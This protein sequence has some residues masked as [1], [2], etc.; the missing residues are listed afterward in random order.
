MVVKDE[1]SNASDLT[2][3]KRRT[4]D[5]LAE[6]RRLSLQPED[7]PGILLTVCERQLMKRK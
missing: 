2:E 7:F 5:D 6:D 1:L 3:S 4:G